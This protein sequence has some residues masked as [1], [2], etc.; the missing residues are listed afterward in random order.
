MQKGVEILRK[1]TQI[2]GVLIW[3]SDSGAEIFRC[4]FFVSSH[5]R[6]G[7]QQILKI[8]GTDSSQFVGS[9]TWHAAKNSCMSCQLK[10]GRTS[11]S[12]HE[13]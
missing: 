9:A 2:F 5:I 3:M 11:S 1:A 6:L 12:R 8:F 13:T 4:T 10:L 7:P